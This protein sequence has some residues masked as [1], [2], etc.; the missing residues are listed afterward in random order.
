M[1]ELLICSTRDKNLCPAK[2][3][4]R[5]EGVSVQI[6]GQLVDVQSLGN[7][8]ISLLCFDCVY[9]FKANKGTEHSVTLH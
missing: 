2:F 1:S 6:M 5:A 9:H 3:Q 4:V 8:M 7:L